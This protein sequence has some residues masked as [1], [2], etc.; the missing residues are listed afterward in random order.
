MKKSSVQT[1]VAIGIGAALFFVLGR[2][3]AIPSPVPNTNISIQY[4]LLAFMAA[5]FGPVAG[6]LIG[7]IGHALIDFSYGWGVWWSWVIASGV[8][9]GIMGLVGKKFKL[10]EGEFGKAAIVKFNLIQLVGHVI[11]WGAVAPVLDIL[12]YAEPVEKLF[13]Q[14]LVSAVANIVTTAVVGTLLCLA[15]AAAKPKKGSLKAE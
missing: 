15:Y 5:L 6:I 8:F 10:N 14:G 9:G 12:I 3:V 1:I 2:F 11:C 7:L 4:G 13:A